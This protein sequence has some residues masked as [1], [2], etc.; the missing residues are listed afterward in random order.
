[1][2]L[3]R[4]LKTEMVNPSHP[5][6]FD[7]SLL[8]NVK[9]SRDFRLGHKILVDRTRELLEAYKRM[10]PYREVI[11]T[12]VYR[13]PEEQQRLYKK[14]RFGNPGPIVTNCDGFTKM[15]KHNKFPAR[16]VDCAI[17]EGGKTIWDEAVFWP[18]GALARE[19]NLVWGGDWESF[20][21]YP[22]LEL[23]E[24]VV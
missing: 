2:C 17:T 10:F 11:V 4:L 3:W 23:P 14:G 8:N 15:S 1:M 9:S 20:K 24:G 16:A 22:H 6:D 13:S 5:S 21:D 7:V 18:F 12:C 19:C